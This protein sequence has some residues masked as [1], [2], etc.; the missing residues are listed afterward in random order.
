MN[1]QCF[2]MLRVVGVVIIVY[3]GFAVT[4]VYCQ[5]LI[6][7]SPPS[8]RVHDY[9][10]LQ[11]SGFGTS[12]G[13]SLVRFTDGVEIWDAGKAYVWRDNFIRV[14]VPVG[15]L[16]GT[17]VVPISKDLLQVFVQTSA[18]PSESLTF[19]VITAT[20]G[21]LEFRRLTD[22]SGD[23][24][25]STV[26]GSPN[27]NYARSKDAELGDVNG[28]GFMDILDNNSSNVQNN[29]HGTLRIN[30]QDKTFTAIALEQRTAD[31]SGTFATTPAGGDYLGNDTSYDADLLDINNDSLPDI[32]QTASRNPIPADG[33]ANPRIRILVND[34]TAPGNFIEDTTSRLPLGLLGT[35]GCP[36]D[37][38]HADINN[39][40]WLDFLVTMRTG[41]PFLEH[42][43]GDTSV[44]QV[45][46][47]GEHI[48]GTD[49]LETWLV[50]LQK[51]AA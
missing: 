47:N 30:N 2:W 13:S 44:T 22:I 41:G 26:L 32:L 20:T 34:P 45:F 38:D 8:Q 28:D 17:T 19:Q 21:T 11:G 33:N 43:L 48:G 49:A 29:A 31:D 39:D 4:P 14:R 3:L 7:V 50:Q 1:I 51:A 27:L 18:G 36:D 10:E 24:D 12:Q 37:I 9:I 35:T 42:C 40:G 6:S 25:V 16:V 15:K 23:Q 46:I 5:T